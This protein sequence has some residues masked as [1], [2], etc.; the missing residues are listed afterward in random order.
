MGAAIEIAFT[1]M[2]IGDDHM[3]SQSQGSSGND[4]DHLIARRGHLLV[5][6]SQQLGEHPARSVRRHQT[7]AD[8]V[9][10]HERDAATGLP[11]LDQVIQLILEIRAPAAQRLLPGAEPVDHGSEPGA[12][13][14]DQDR[15]RS[16][17]Q[18]RGS[19]AGLDR[20]PVRR[21]PRSMIGDAR[22]PFGV[23]CGIGWRPD[24]DIGDLGALGEQRSRRNATC[25]SVRRR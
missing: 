13:A 17:A 10:H 16:V 18:G 15:P 4:Q 5:D 14:I 20:A 6:L 23:G 11:R 7:P 25:R 24:C 2:I 1:V 21:A 19:I 9:G 8:L 3:T 22:G 12:E